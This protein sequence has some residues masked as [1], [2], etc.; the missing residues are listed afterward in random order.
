MKPPVAN[1]CSVE[2]ARG[3]RSRL[4]GVKTISG[5]RMPRRSVPPYIWRRSR[6][7]YC[8][9]VVQLH[10]CMLFSAHSVRKRS[11]RA[12]ECSGPWP[13]EA[14]RQ[15]HHQAARLAPLGF[16][17]GD[18]LVDHDLRAVGEVAEL[19]FP[20]HQRQRIG[21]AVAEFEAQHGVFAQRA[22]VHVEARLVRRDVLHGDVALAGFVIVER[23][24]ALAER[25]AAGILAAEA[26]GRAFEQ[27]ACRRRAIRRTP[28]RAAPP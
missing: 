26:D 12:L 16:G 28:N 3:W 19:R 15:Q 2:T 25:A 11:M 17:A 4:L 21:H 7:K 24:V 14:V 18:E 23:Q 22:V 20:D 1:S 10:T 27:P 6:W 13:F 9:G 5:L 8:A